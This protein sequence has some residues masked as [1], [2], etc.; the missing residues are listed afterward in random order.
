MHVRARALVQ[1][2]QCILQLLDELGVIGLQRVALPK[3]S[4]C[5]SVC[6][7]VR[8]VRTRGGGMAS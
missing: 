6:A 8:G 4:L 1:A 3:N 5:A 2:C 7:R